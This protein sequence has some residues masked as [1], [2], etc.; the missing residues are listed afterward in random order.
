MRASRTSGLSA[1]ALTIDEERAQLERGAESAVGHPR[2]HPVRRPI[3]DPTGNDG[4][5][6]STPTL[7]AGDAALTLLCEKLPAR[8]RTRPRRITPRNERGTTTGYNIERGITLSRIEGA[9][10]SLRQSFFD[11]GFAQ[12]N[13]LVAHH[14]QRVGNYVSLK[15][16]L[17]CETPL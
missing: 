14:G 10:N 2:G 11:G 4:P 15:S 12:V 16:G 6:R 3:D 17:L 5:R 1:I 7:G 13:D 8:T 9:A